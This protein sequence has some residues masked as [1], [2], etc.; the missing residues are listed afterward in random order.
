MIDY[1]NLYSKTPPFHPAEQTL[2][3]FDRR[4]TLQKKKDK[5]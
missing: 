4:Y 2:Q 5:S 1:M 3:P